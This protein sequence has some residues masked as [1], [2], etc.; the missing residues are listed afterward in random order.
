MYTLYYTPGACSIS[1][2]IALRETG[3]AF[4]LD[5][6][7]LRAK[8]TQDGGDF[9][10]VNPSGYVPALR[11]P[12]GEIMTEG[13]VIVQ[14]LAD[15]APAAKLAPPAGT[16]QRYR[17]MEWMNFIATELHKGQSPLLNVLAGDDLKEQLSHK[18]VKRFH[19]VAEAMGTNEWLFGSQ[20]TIVDGYLFYNM[21]LWQKA[22]KRELPAEL[23]AY[24]Q[25]LAARPSI[26]ASLAAEGIGA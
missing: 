13:A 14:Y 9:L 1:P 23:V 22:V 15:Q 3:L 18:L 10:A 26:A 2:H 4:T 12:S 25:R 21:R 24:Y 16:M 7:D 6:V 19:H 20:F 17:L 5:K 11:L 8:K